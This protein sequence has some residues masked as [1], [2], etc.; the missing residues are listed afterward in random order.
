[1]QNVVAVVLS[2]NMYIWRADSGEVVQIREAPKG[3]CVP[4]VD[5]K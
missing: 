4:S 1:V 2:R 3:T 5:L